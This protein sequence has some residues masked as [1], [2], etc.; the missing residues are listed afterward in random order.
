MCSENERS[1]SKKGLKKCFSW[2]FIVSYKFIGL[3]VFNLYIASSSSGADGDR[4]N[5]D[6]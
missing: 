6:P 5:T 4:Q 2:K 3:Q 1:V